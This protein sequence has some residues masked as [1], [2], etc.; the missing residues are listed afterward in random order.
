MPDL[1]VKNDVQVGWNTRLVPFGQTLYLGGF[2]HR[3]CLSCGHGLRR[4][5]AG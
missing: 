5:Q 3:F 2:R 4:Y 1:L